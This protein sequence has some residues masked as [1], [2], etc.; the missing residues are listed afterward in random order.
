MAI[1]RAADVESVGGCIFYDVGEAEDCA[2]DEGVLGCVFDRQ[3][4]V[5]ER[6]LGV[7]LGELVRW[8]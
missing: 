8:I 5:V 4:P 7:D 3:A 2:W 1:S 6:S